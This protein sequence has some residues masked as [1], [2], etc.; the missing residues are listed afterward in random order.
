MASRSS[1]AFFLQ[2]SR[3]ITHSNKPDKDCFG[4]KDTY[5]S[6]QFFGKFMWV[7]KYENT[8]NVV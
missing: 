2:Q 1:K 7:K 3:S 8:Y 4:T 5:N 6:F